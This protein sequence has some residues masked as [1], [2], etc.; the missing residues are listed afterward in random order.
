M[1]FAALRRPLLAAALTCALVAAGTATAHAWVFTSIVDFNLTESW[2]SYG[3]YTI[4]ASG[5][6]SASYRWSDDPDHTTIISANNCIDLSMFG[7]ATIPAHDT[8]YHG[9]YGGV[10]GQC[11]VL[12][13]RTA[14]G[15]GSMYNH[16]GV[17]R[18]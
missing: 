11:F 2:S 16:D 12:R 13:G 6:G 10:A 7:S 5:D 3:N 9:L 1:P 4:S 18:R 14:T 15:A 8:A 17:L